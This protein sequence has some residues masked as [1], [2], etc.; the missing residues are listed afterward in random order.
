MASLLLSVKSLIY[1]IP[2]DFTN[3]QNTM[4]TVI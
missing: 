2:I 4:R 1:T 3:D